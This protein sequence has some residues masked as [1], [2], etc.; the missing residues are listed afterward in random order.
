MAHDYYQCP[1][2]PGPWRHTWRLIIFCLIVNDFG[3]EY[4]RK[5]HALHLKQALAEHYEITENWKGDL[6]SGI[7]IEWNYD[8]N[9][10]KRTVRL[11]MDYY[12]SNLRVK[13]DHPEPKR[14]T[15]AIRQ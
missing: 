4:V 9:H 1:L 2:T 11:A 5:Q 15:A 3:V 6:Y 12:I 14:I 7:N 8:P 13:Y 10:Y